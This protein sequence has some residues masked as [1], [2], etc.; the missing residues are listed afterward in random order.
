MAPASPCPAAACSQELLPPKQKPIVKTG[1]RSA[2]APAR[3]SRTAAATSWVRE[4]SRVRAMCSAKENSSP[5][6]PTPAVRPK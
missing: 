2:P 3:S 6:F 1:R 5:R 4:P